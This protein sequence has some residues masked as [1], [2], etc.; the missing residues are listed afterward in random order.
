MSALWGLL[1]VCAGSL[2]ALCRWRSDLVVRGWVSGVAA[3]ART[4]RA[5]RAAAGGTGAPER[6][7]D[8]PVNPVELA[9]GI[10]VVNLLGCLMAG[11]AFGWTSGAGYAWFVV[12]T[13]FLG[14]FTTFSTAMVDV[15]N[16]LRMR[17]VWTALALALGT[18]AGGVCACLA[19]LALGGALA[20]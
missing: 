1:M 8:A 3:R 13:G 6:V 18:W 11:L 4:R 5:V 17:R 15:L 9:M 12:G 14:G 2:G 19:G 7:A 10:V 20:G 16:Q